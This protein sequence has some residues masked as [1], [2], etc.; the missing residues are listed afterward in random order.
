MN[1][2]IAASCECSKCYCGLSLSWPTVVAVAIVAVL[3]G[4][5]FWTINNQ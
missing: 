1:L 4:W 2:L 5:I 3:I